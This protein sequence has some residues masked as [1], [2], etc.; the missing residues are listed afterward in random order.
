MW[1]PLYQLHQDEDDLLHYT[2]TKAAFCVKC[3]KWFSLGGTIHNAKR[4]LK[5][6]IGK[7]PGENVD[8]I[9]D[10]IQDNI[11]HKDIKIIQDKELSTNINQ[12]IVEYILL[13]SL[14]F[15]LIENKYLRKICD[16][17]C[18]QTVS[19][20]A[21]SIISHVKTSSKAILKDAWTDSQSSKYI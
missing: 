13:H 4:L 14:G 12:C 17:S 11:Q 6:D 15:S 3:H 7:M 16:L 18:R 1:I 9:S 5:K 21:G 2:Y 10:I 8:N 19:L 20:F